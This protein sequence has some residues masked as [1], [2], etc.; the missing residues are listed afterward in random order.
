MPLGCVPIVARANVQGAAQIPHPSLDVS[1]SGH[2][3]GQGSA[4]MHTQLLVGS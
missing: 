4:S 1:D 3:S 2:A